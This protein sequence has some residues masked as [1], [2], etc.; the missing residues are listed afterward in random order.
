LYASSG[1]GS[2]DNGEVVGVETGDNAAGTQKEWFP[3]GNIL[4]IKYGG[5][6]VEKAL[7]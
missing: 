2:I 3:V 7:L 6:A 4:G 1:K 5:D